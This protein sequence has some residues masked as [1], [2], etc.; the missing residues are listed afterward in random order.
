MRNV[1]RALAAVAGAFLMVFGVIAV[2]ML[3]LGLVQGGASG[4]VVVAGVVGAAG[5]LAAPRLIPS[6]RL[7]DGYA[8]L[9]YAMLFIPILIVVVYAFNGGRYV[10]VWEGF[11]T[12]WFSAA[13]RDDQ[14]VESILRSLRIALATAVV[15][16]VLGT[17]AAL[18]MVRLRA[19]LR[20]PIEVVILLTI[21]LPEI[22]LAIAVLTFLSNTGFALGS[23]AILAG[24]TIFNV[25]YVILL[26]RS[27][28]VAMGGALEQ[29]SRDLGAGPIATFVQVTLP[30]LAPAVLAG[31]LLTF[32][33]SFDDVVM[34]NFVS[35]SGNDTWPLRV[36]SSLRFG[37][38]PNL[39]AA[40]TM[41]LGVTLLGLLLV[42]L[43][44]WRGT[45]RDASPGPALPR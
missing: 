45:R 29:A 18:A 22:V 41:M 5:L 33:F 4:R 15:S 11:S 9:V 27:R 28:F 44:L 13:L 3:A 12:R 7:L 23:V 10:T 17:C 19:R 16:T 21:V 25:S 35:G 34:S 36:L 42:G 26:V 14:I 24:H 1:G 32:T 38:S 40:A 6:G 20:A 31:A 30:Q 39:N 2:A 8:V 37:V 43:V